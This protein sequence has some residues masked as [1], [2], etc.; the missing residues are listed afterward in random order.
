MSKKTTTITINVDEA[1]LD[2]LNREG[3]RT[4]LLNEL[5]GVMMRIKE[6]GFYLEVRYA[7]ETWEESR[8]KNLFSDCISIPAEMFAKAEKD[9]GWLDI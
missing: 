7:P 4:E 6:A 5:S 3:L 2:R 9:N 8:R 1:M